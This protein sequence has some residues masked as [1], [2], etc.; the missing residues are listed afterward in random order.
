MEK[1]Q[2]HGIMGTDSIVMKASIVGVIDLVLPA[3]IVLPST[4][5]AQEE[6]PNEAT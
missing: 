3:A 1:D 5:L 6:L 2:I 4:I